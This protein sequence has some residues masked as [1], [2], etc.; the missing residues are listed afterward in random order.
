MLFATY[1]D[2]SVRV[3]GE[4]EEVQPPIRQSL[5]LDGLGTMQYVSSLSS[6][7]QVMTRVKNVSYQ[8]DRGEA[9]D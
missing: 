5:N 8:A 2:G 4:D 9:D 1:A 3:Q 7:D 6:N